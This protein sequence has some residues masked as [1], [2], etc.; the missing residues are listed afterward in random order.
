LHNLLNLRGGLLRKFSEL[1]EFQHGSLTTVR[2]RCGKDNCHC[3]KPADS[4]RRPQGSTDSEEG[5]KDR[6]P[7]LVFPCSAEKEIAAIRRFQALTHE[8]VVVNQKICRL[9]PIEGQ[10]HTGPVEEIQQEVTRELK[11]LLL[12]IFRERG[13]QGGQDMDAGVMAIRSA[14]VLG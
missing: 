1:G 9:R 2:R 5:W 3:A 11:H 10:A 6:Y 13:N 7:N 4:G 14:S 8:L 12:L